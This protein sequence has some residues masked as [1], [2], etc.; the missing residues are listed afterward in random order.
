MNLQ[1]YFLPFSVAW[2]SEWVKSLSW[3]WLFATQWTVAHQAPPSMGFSRHF[4][5][6]LLHFT[7]AKNLYKAVHRELPHLPLQSHYIPLCD[8]TL[9]NFL[10][11]TLALFSVVASKLHYAHFILPLY[12]FICRIN[13]Q[14][15]NFWAK[16]YTF[17]SWQFLSPRHRGG[18][19]LYFQQQHNH[20]HD[21]GW[22]TMKTYI[23]FIY[24]KTEKF[25]LMP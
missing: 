9:T 19:N 23:P 7:N 6:L 17:T 2:V 24:K 8:C 3:V 15:W 16:E 14:K 18:A 21:L 1:S 4:C 10:W 20:M 11:T 25:I 22:N 12:K 13:F 5:S